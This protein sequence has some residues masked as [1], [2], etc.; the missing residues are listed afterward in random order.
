M[1]LHP[2]AIENWERKSGTL[3]LFLRIPLHEDPIE[4]ISEFRLGS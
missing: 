2:I 4:L 1:F 3:F